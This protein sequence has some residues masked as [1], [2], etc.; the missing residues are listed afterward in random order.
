MRR[1]WSPSTVIAR[2]TAK[3]TLKSAVLWA[4]IFSAYTASKTLTYTDT[5]PDTATRLKVVSSFGHNMGLRAILGQPHHL[6][7]VSGFA[8]WNTLGFLIIIGS[9]WALTL[10]TRYFRGDEDSGRSELML[11]GPTTQR[12]NA[13]NILGGLTISLVLLFTIVATVFVIIGRQKGVNFSLTNSLYFALSCT[14]GAALFLS[15]GALTSQIMPT[16]ALAAGLAT[17]FFGITFLLRALGDISGAKWLL[18]VSPQGWIE[19]LG[20][21]YNSEWVWLL[22]IGA[23]IA[24]FAGLAI[25]FAGRRD[26]GAALI[27]EKSTAKSNFRLLS[28]PFLAGLRF[29]KNSTISWLAALLAFGTFYG[30][31]TKTATQAISSIGGTNGANAQ[32]AF[33]HITH[34]SP[35]SLTYTF[36]SIIFFL[37]MPI[38]MCFVASS[39]NKFREDEGSGYADNF[40]VGP[41]SR[42]KWLGGR[43]ALILVFTVVACLVAGTGIWLGQASQHL[44]IAPHSL[45]TAS[46]NVVAPAIFTL[47]VAVLAMGFVPRLTS[48]LAYSVA[49]WSF[50]IAMLSSGLNLNHWIVDTSLMQH[51]SLAPASNPNWSGNFIIM[52][53]GAIMIVIGL[54]RFNYRDLQSE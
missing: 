30:L 40:L 43:V 11:G 53:I 32:K 7:T 23:L 21:L 41:V 52:A 45:L 37:L 31:I 36:V 48:L 2:F 44:G 29:T 24:L 42:L 22:P 51:I 3:R 49:G 25:Y 47:G 1:F 33:T 6:E 4:F 20:P 46:L 9:V 14:T 12:Q 26:M 17:G 39:S 27:Q 34:S 8:A 50:L 18:N 15:V 10:A 5:F 54:I 38:V 19:K 28:N 35:V 13:A 16:R